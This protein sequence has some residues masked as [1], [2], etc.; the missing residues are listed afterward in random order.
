MTFNLILKKSI[1]HLHSSIQAAKPE[2]IREGD[3]KD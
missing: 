2:L 3:G 1:T